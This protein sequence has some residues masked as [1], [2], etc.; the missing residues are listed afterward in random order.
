LTLEEQRQ[1]LIKAL[2]KDSDLHEKGLFSQLGSDF[3]QLD[4]AATGIFEDAKAQQAFAIAWNFWDSWIDERNHLFPGFYE[5]IAKE[6]W[7]V[8]AR[9]VAENLENGH[10]VVDPLLLKHFVFHPSIPL[11]ERIRQ[12]RAKWLNDK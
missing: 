2:R 8:L 10:E 12:L 11:K 3:D 7:P 6:H 9:R 4:V 5:G 1:A